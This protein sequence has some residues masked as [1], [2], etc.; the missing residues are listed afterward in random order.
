MSM[1]S[2]MLPPEPRPTPPTPLPWVQEGSMIY[3]PGE[4]GANICALLSPRASTVVGYT[5][6]G[7][8]DPDIKEAY[9]NGAYLVRAVN[10]LPAALAALELVLSDVLTSE[11]APVCTV[12]PC[13][14][15][16]PAVRAQIAAA[17]V[18]A[19]GETP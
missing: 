10:A 3:A 14:C 19:K 15:G 5:P 12:Q 4:H 8:S 11:H 9:A 1:E 18:A 16:W 6:L 2:P 7:Y 13:R 17:L